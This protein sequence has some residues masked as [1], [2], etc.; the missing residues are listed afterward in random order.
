MVTREPKQMGP[1]QM[2][3]SFYVRNLRA[4]I[5]TQPLMQQAV[6][7]MLYDEE[8]R[9]L[10]ARTP[11]GLWMTIGG[12]IDPE[13]TPADA[14]VREFW[15]ETGILVEPVR[16]LGVFG[17]PEFR[18]T[19]ENGDV[20][21]YTS[22]VFEVRSVGGEAQPDG[23]EA[24]ELQ[25]VSW[26]EA[27]SLPCTIPTRRL[28]EIGFNPSNTPYFQPARWKPSPSTAGVGSSG[29]TT[30]VRLPHSN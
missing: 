20:M 27:A 22:T 24:L 3:M 9:V 7:M 8:G 14:A 21:L 6:T 28:L 12:A 13:E 19:Y 1:G 29:Q 25:F 5:G 2:P 30:E 17:G 23:E 15:E 26:Q 18:I 16:I 10:V 11:G 4:K